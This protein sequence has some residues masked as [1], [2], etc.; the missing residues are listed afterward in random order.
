[1]HYDQQLLSEIMDALAL[2]SLQFK[3]QNKNLFEILKGQID[4]M[5]PGD[6]LP[7][8]E[9]EKRAGTATTLSR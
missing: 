5:K 4:P 8:T 9:Q 6:K 3:N 2:F 7:H 1:V